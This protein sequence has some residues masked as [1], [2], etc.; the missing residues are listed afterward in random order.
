[1]RPTLSRKRST[2]L[3]TLVLKQYTVEIVHKVYEFSY[4]T[5]SSQPYWINKRIL[6]LIYQDK[7]RK[8]KVTLWPVCTTI[9][10][11]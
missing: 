5:P 9:V 10:A 7:Q 2:V 6:F 8:Y 3:I 4:D 1:M 11:V